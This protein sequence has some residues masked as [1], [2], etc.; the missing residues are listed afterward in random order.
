MCYQ[1]HGLSHGLGSSRPKTSTVTPASV[2]FDEFKSGS[3]AYT[4]K[5]APSDIIIDMAANTS[6]TSTNA[7]SPPVVINLQVTQLSCF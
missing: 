1:V 5:E 7:S 3:V 2:S 6:T 4:Y